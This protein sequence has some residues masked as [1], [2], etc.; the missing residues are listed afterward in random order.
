MR[1]Q[2]DVKGA[3]AEYTKAIQLEPRLWKAW[4]NRAIAKQQS[5]D[6]A[7][8]VED[9]RKCLEVAPHDAQERRQIEEMLAKA[10]KSLRR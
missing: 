4:Q 5:G 7:G 1:A 9:L 3:I 2:G 6:V 8:A 10:Q